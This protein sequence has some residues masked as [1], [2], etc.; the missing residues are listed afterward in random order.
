MEEICGIV[1]QPKRRKNEK[2]YVNGEDDRLT[3]VGIRYFFDCLIMWMCLI[4]E[5]LPLPPFDLGAIAYAHKHTIYLFLIIVS[6]KSWQEKI[7]APHPHKLVCSN[8]ICAFIKGSRHL[9]HLRAVAMRT[10]PLVALL[11]LLKIA[12]VGAQ[13][14]H[15]LLLRHT[16]PVEKAQP[17]IELNG[18]AS[19]KI[20]ETHSS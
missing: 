5:S 4:Y 17:K 13:L 12:V 2:P 11:R 7:G 20:L 16:V 1:R 18:Y 9:L 10:L 19:A 8:E 15:V 6:H 14:A 3:Y